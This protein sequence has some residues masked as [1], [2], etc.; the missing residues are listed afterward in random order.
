MWPSSALFEYRRIKRIT[1]N[2]TAPVAVNSREPYPARKTVQTLSLC[3]RRPA[4]EAAFHRGPFLWSAADRVR[5]ENIV[6]A[7]EMT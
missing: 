6:I 1:T 7:E 2:G 5:G 4:S 3:G